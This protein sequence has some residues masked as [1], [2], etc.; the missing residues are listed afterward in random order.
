[1]TE[2]K[3][4]PETPTF[5]I[6]RE[7]RSWMVEKFPGWS[8]GASQSYSSDI[9]NSPFNAQTIK[10]I[11]KYEKLY[12]SFKSVES[13][14]VYLAV[15][16]ETFTDCTWCSEP[17]DYALYLAPR[18]LLSYVF[19]ALCLGLGTMTARKAFWRLYGIIALTG[20]LIVEAYFLDQ[21]A[22][23]IS[24]GQANRDSLLVSPNESHMDTV[25]FYRK[26]GFGCLCF[27]V[28]LI[29]GSDR[30]ADHERLR[31]VIGAQMGIYGRLQ[32]SRL[33]RAAILGDSNLR[34]KFNEYHKQEQAH[35]E[36]MEKDIEYK[37]TSK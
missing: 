37:V 22:K 4:T 36:A 21:V 12:E 6:R 13:R 24:N 35:M 14:R 32:G 27:V 5:V 31:G 1:M 20:S 19:M 26:I 16:H 15:G 33:A 2:W 28:W 17:S 23:S 3:S 8:E 10:E 34:S 18:V 25:N 29:D 9:Q 11:E 7:F 30:L